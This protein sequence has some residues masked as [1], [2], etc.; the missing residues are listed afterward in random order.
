MLSQFVRCEH[1][2]WKACV[3][4]FGSRT[5]VQFT[6]CAVNTPLYGAF[7]LSQRPAI[8]RKDDR[9]KLFEMSKTRRFRRRLSVK[10]VSDNIIIVP[11]IIITSC[12]ST[13]SQRP[14][15][16]CPLTDNCENIDHS[17]SRHVKVLPISLPKV[18][19]PVGDSSP[20]LIHD[21]LGPQRAHISNGIRSVQPLL[22]GSRLTVS[23]SPSAL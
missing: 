18:S 12:Y 8:S 10:V 7:K 5:P 14:H 15:R 17:K 16:C 4:N 9:Q 22:Y 2:H 21:S 20:H 6:S 23:N 13:G 3:Q 1:S 11:I 19:L